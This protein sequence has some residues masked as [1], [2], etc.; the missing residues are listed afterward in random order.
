MNKAKRN[1]KKIEI[2]QHRELVYGY[3]LDKLIEGK[4]PPEYVTERYTKLK[5]V[6]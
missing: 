3:A 4:R 5:Q 1:R 2:K 6:R